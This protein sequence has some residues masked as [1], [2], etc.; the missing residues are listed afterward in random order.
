MAGHLEVVA[1]AA[2]IPIGGSGKAV[3]AAARESVGTVAET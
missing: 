2:L 3:V 1:A